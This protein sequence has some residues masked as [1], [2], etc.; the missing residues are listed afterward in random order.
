MGP[1][2]HRSRSAAGAATSESGSTVDTLH[3]PP[4]AII[5]DSTCGSA[6]VYGSDFDPNTMVCAGFLSGGVDACQGDS[7]GPLEAPL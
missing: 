6:S 2:Q 7:G 5:S 1:G 3:A 4:G